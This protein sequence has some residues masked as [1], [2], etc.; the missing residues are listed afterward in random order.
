MKQNKRLY[1]I[2]ASEHI[3]IIRGKK[4]TSVYMTDSPILFLIFSI[5]IVGNIVAFGG[6][7][8]SLSNN[9]N[10]KVDKPKKFSKK[11]EVI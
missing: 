4:L 11:I 6:F 7:L 5:P 9:I 1:W 3:A 10:I 2:R 8:F